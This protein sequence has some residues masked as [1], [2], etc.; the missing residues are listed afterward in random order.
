MA[1][2]FFGIGG[3]YGC[4]S[5]F[6]EYP[7]TIND[8]VYKTNEHYFQA[9]K[10]AI[11]E[12]SYAR[13]IQQASSPAEARRMGRSREYGLRSDWEEVKDSIMRIAVI[14]KFH[15]HKGIQEIL[16][17]T[18]TE[19][20]IEANPYDYYWGEGA[21]R[22]GKN[23]LGRILMEIRDVLR[24]ELNWDK[25]NLPEETAS[26]LEEYIKTYSDKIEVLQ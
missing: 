23:M 24:A 18:G 20:I 5:N 1:I 26:P 8:Q 6:S 17:S 21:K 16:L 14:T 2:R 9:Q 15:T 11:T 4:F 25:L 10:F 19:E 22:N 13:Q 12:L 7:I 3:K